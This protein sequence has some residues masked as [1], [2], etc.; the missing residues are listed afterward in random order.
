M[1]G[2]LIIT[3][4]LVLNF[5]A[6]GHALMYKRDPRTAWAWIVTCLLIPTIGP[7]LYFLLGINRI[8]TRAKKLKGEP[9]LVRKRIRPESD[10]QGSL[11]SP[12]DM[13][14]IPGYLQMDHLSRTISN[15]PLTSGNSI[16]VLYNGDQAYPRMLEDIDKAKKC[17]YLSTFIFDT[18]NTGRRF[19]SSLAK[20][21]KRGVDVRVLLDGIGEFYSWPRA[22]GYLKQEK[23]PF[24]RFLPPRMVPLS[25]FINLRNHRKMLVI[26]DDTVFT[27]G[28]NIGDRH[29]V[30][31]DKSTG[32]QDVQF[33]LAGP[34]ALQMKQVFLEDWAFCTGE[35]YPG[36][37]D[38]AKDL[39]SGDAF[40]RTI[41]VG[42]D[43]DL[44]KLRMLL[45][46]MISRAVERVSI[47]TPYF[48]PSQELIGAMQVA[49]LRGVEINVVLPARNNLPYVHWATRNM[50]WEILQ[51]GVRVYYQPPPFSH[52]K[53][54]LVD[55]V[56]ALIGSANMDP[57]SLRLN[58]EMV[59]E[60]YSRDL[61]R[62][63]TEHFQ[64]KISRSKRVRLV[65]V[66]SRSIPVRLRDSL[67]W[68][69]S[70]YL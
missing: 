63:L 10:G 66:D 58:F 62:T 27:G 32:T 23:V 67:C 48:L 56:Y 41:T 24:A 14:E 64:E 16:R 51:Y 4:V 33:R 36:Q 40:C 59:V 61:V 21:R 57:R 17:V 60:I 6:A 31:E 43:Q 28:M 26:D 49:A 13:A 52:S 18:G 20:A 53:L 50:L 8:R 3:L 47:M 65:D 7:V 2:W 9:M 25:P 19:I 70:P 1:S 5:M 55:D 35:P 22:G 34:V 44:D 30:D 42:P 68:L 38:Q 15:R 45:T 12:P 69:F 37:M 11:Y 54:F 29:L 39:S 46:G